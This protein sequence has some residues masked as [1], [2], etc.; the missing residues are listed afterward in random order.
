[1][2]PSRELAVRL[3]DLR[4]GARLRLGEG[5][6]L[7][8]AF[9]DVYDCCDQNEAALAI[10]QE[11]VRLGASAVGPLVERLRCRADCFFDHCPPTWVLID[12]GAA[13]V[14]RL[15]ACLADANPY[16]RCAAAGLL[17]RIDTFA[18]PHLLQRL[19]EDPFPEVRRAAAGAAA[20]HGYRPVVPTLLRILSE[21]DPDWGLAHSL[22]VRALGRLRD[23]R[24]VA[25]LK[26]VVADDD[27]SLMVR[28]EALEALG[29]LGG[30]G[31]L[32]ALV[33]RLYEKDET[34]IEGAIVGLGRL[35]SRQAAGAL[36]AVIDAVDENLRAQIARALGSI[37]GRVAE[38]ALQGLMADADWHVRLAAAASLRELLALRGTTDDER[39]LIR[40]SR[41]REGMREFHRH[42]FRDIEACHV[43]L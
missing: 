14:D 26:T 3:A 40:L 20:F 41:S 18:A 21:E 34:L 38:V 32:G 17:G 39:A 37:G 5:Q 15:C 30:P 7:A 22:A 12:I 35:G 24:A 6:D 1:M 16:V 4:R 42:A 11:L 19:W 31:V 9:L 27:E 29:E 28:L 2:P 36:V 43:S 8:Q 33:A 25:A 23:R 10:E 13:S